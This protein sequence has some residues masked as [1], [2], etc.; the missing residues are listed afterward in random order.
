MT[1]KYWGGFR[2]IAY[3]LQQYRLEARRKHLT[4]PHY[5][6]SSP[7][8]Y[9]KV[10]RSLIVKGMDPEKVAADLNWT[11]E[12]VKSVVFYYFRHGDLKQ[13]PRIPSGGRFKMLTPEQEQ[14]IVKFKQ[15]NSNATMKQ[16]QSYVLWDQVNF[17]QVNYISQSTLRLLLRKHGFGKS[18]EKQICTSSE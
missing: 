17:P 4:L 12:E 6:E 7:E 3:W 15:Q 1:F 10:N 11:V 2:K 9:S 16:I 13:K 18:K 8:I 14:L 5:D